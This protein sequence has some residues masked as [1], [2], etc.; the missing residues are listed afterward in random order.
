MPPSKST[1]IA[2]ALREEIARG[3]FKAGDRLPSEADLTS[4]FGVS[5]PT[6]RAALAKLVN[7]GLVVSE[8]GRGSFVRERT[9][10]TYHAE[11][12]ERVKGRSETDA[13]VSEVQ[14]EGR[15]PKQD[16]SMHI[17]PAS[18]EVAVRLNVDEG[19]LVVVRRCF[20]YV[21]GQPWSDQDSYYPMDI[22]EAAGLVTPK[23]IPEGTIRAMAKAGHDE[24]GH[25][26]EIT[27]RMPT[28]AEAQVLDI[29]AGTPLLVYSRT[30]HSD[31]RPVRLTRTL[32]PADRNRITYE[33]GDLSALAGEP[34]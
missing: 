9:V 2:D 17:E 27:A 31:K 18:T 4:R 32:F 3:V 34:A 5:R 7:E 1:R 21:D 10:L 15:A 12:A 28:P 14:E 19:S 8:T 22:A 25:V 24:V 26:D 23:D 29:G 11:R 6:I 30:A 13:Y 33:L 20:R 16:F